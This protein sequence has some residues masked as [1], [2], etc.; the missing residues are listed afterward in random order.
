MCA[1]KERLVEY[2]Y[3]DCS[4]DDRRRMAAHLDVC[5]A[6][7]HELDGL[8]GVRGHLLAWTP[9]ELDLGF[10]IVREKAPSRTPWFAWPVPAWGL[11]LAASLVLVASLAAGGLEV[12]FGD[13]AMVVRSGWANTGTATPAS[14]QLASPATEDWRRELASFEQ[15]LRAELGSGP[16]EVAA[17][18]PAAAPASKDADVLRRVRTLLEESE[19]RQ[20]QELALRLAQVVQD[21]DRQRQVDL[22]RIQQGFGRLEGQSTAEAA[23]QRETLN[24]LMRVSQ[25]P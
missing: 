14:R 20:K 18:Q 6:C 11:V 4:D 3:G 12:R 23:R 13:G 7:A 1:E 22:I 17:E 9:P 8:R 10:R 16:R 19:Q 5:A 25:R 21:F 24:Y 15:R 2:L